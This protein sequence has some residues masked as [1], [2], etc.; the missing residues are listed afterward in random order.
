MQTKS[1]M[2][3]IFV[4][5]LLGLWTK[6]EIKLNYDL[7]FNSSFVFISCSCKFLQSR[8][9]KEFMS[10]RFFVLEQSEMKQ[11]FNPPW[12]LKS[13]LCQRISSC[14]KLRISI[15]FKG[16]Q[17]PSSLSNI[18]IFLGD[19]IVTSYHPTNAV[20]ISSKQS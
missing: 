8:K 9:T 19:I 3:K 15:G 18:F 5:D 14:T 17:P 12:V 13:C 1:R 6:D 16:I 7:I 11:V 4:N 2:S 10:L 20:N